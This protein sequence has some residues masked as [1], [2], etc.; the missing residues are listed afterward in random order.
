MLNPLVRCNFKILKR[1]TEEV[2][3]LKKMF[4]LKTIADTLTH[5]QASQMETT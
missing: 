5:A 1:K 2:I 4:H 3:I